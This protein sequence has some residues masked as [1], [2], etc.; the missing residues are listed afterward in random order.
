AKRTRAL[1]LFLLA[2]VVVAGVVS[3]PALSHD[4][5]RTIYERTIEYQANRGSPFSVWGLYGGLGGPQEAV[6]IAAVIL[7]LLLAVLP[8]RGD[9]IGLA[10]ACAAVMIAVQLGIDHWFYLYIPWFFGLVMVAL[11]SSVEPSAPAPAPVS[12]PQDQAALSLSRPSPYA[13]R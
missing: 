5:L 12:W 3:I 7:A 11:L 2:F 6:Q 13:L 10:A 4:S 9:V 8:R 1:S